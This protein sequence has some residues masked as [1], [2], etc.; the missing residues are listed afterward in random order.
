M[1]RW[2]STHAHWQVQHDLLARFKGRFGAHIVPVC[3][4]RSSNPVALGNAGDVV[5]LVGFDGGA[6]VNDFW[7]ERNVRVVGQVARYVLLHRG[8]A[9][10]HQ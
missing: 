4:L 2:R 3:H 8:R 9:R 7:R 1:V 6:A 5:V 10:H